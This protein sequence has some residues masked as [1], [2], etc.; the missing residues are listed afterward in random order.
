[1]TLPHLP[2][3][4]PESER[5]PLVNWLLQVIDQQQEVIAKL[6]EKVSQLEK[7]VGSLDEELK[8]AKKLPGQPQIRPSTLNQEEKQLKPRGKR[9]GSDKRSK[10][11]DFEVDEARLIEP[12]ELPE[13]VRFNGYREYDVQ[14]LILKRHNIRYLLAE[15]VTAE[16][17][18][19]TGKLPVE[20][21]GHYG[22]TLRA[23]VLY[24]H[25]QCRVP[26]PL[27]VEQLREFGIEISTGQVNRLLMEEKAA[28][29]TEQQEVLRA[30]LE[31]AEY[32]HTDDTSARHQGRN[33]YCTVIGNDLFAYFSSSLSKSRENYLR[34]L[35]GQSEDYVLNEYARSYLIMQQLPQ[36]HLSKLQFSSAS[37]AQGEAGWQ[38]YLQ[39]LDITSL[40]AV[41]LLS[42]AA[43]LGSAIEQG[44]SPD[45]I[46]LSD[47]A[48][49]FAILVHALCWVHMERGI[50]RLPGNTEKHRQEIEAVQAELWDYYRQLRDYQNQPSETEQQRLRLR[51]DEIFGQRYPHHG[52][53]N[54]AMQQFC[55]HKEEL[56]RVLDTPQVP[57]HTN[58]AEA[59]IREYVTRRKISGGTRHPD[60]RRA[61][62]TFTGLKKTCRK[63]AYSFWQYLLSRLRGDDGVPYLPDVIRTRAT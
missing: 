58:A 51:F 61:R 12:E 36:S 29:H 57:L 3:E 5:T 41:K 8:A 44:L 6:E 50:R 33:G 59:D 54:L 26:Q 18:T 13:G 20:Q 53:L 1:M 62:D 22:V 2:S 31:T 60:G 39:G 25:H 27:I 14:D 7:K 43:L 21:Q 46:V 15:Y 42:E 35:R 49:Q 28:F 30:G 23:F 34:L 16:G 32:V 11:T 52:G 19:I 10:K 4:I 48:K 56:L 37:V 45:L 40:Q 63:L 17:R 38:A 55:V 9:P 47:G 24:Q